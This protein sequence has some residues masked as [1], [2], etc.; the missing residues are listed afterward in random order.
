MSIIDQLNAKIERRQAEDREFAR[1]TGQTIAELDANTTARDPVIGCLHCTAGSLGVSPDGERVY[2]SC[3]QG[4]RAE[5]AYL[6]LVNQ[7]MMDYGGYDATTHE[8][9]YA[10]RLHGRGATGNLQTA[11]DAL[12]L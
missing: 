11:R 7:W 4:R 3:S 9:L 1:I 10:G 8:R 6:A 5:Q 2:C 12:S